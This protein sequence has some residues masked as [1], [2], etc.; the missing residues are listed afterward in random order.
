MEMFNPVLVHEYLTLSARRFP[1]KD[2]LVCGGERWTYRALDEASGRLAGALGR[3]GLNRQDRV[4]IFLENSAETVVSLYGTLKAGGIFVILNASLRPGKLGYILQDSGARFMIASGKKAGIVKAALSQLPYPPV[5]IWV[6]ETPDIIPGGFPA[7]SDSWKAVLEASIPEK[8]PGH[9][10][11]ECDL[12]TLIYTSGST[13]E[14]KG[15]M[16]THH[17]VVSAARSIIQY[18]ENTPEDILIDVLPLSFD[19]GLYQVIMAFMFGGTV[20]LEKS[21]LYPVTI[22]KAIERERVTG[23]PVVPTL[24]AMLLKMGNLSLYDLGSMRYMTNTAAALPVEHIRRLRALFPRVKLYSMYGLTECKRV[25]YLP[26]EELDRRPASVGKAIPNCEVFIVD[27]EG[28]RAAPG[29]AGELVIRGPNVMQ[30]YWNAP[31]LTARTFRP[32]R[33][34]DDRLLYSGDLFKMDADGFLYFLGRKDDMIKTKGER[35]SPREIENALCGMEGIAEAAVIGVPDEI[36]GEAVE[37]F[38]ALKPGIQV[39]EKSVLKQCAEQLESFLVPRRVKILSELPKSPNGK[40]DK[41][42]LREEH[43]ARTHSRSGLRP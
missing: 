38:V 28:R 41:K 16:S 4:A 11:P 35:V 7:G 5:V 13:G 1:G 37:A 10:C 39:R 32:G 19:Y 40:V 18:L 25:S 9:P 23:F 17:N 20:V 43:H 2:A 29:Q 31:E 3:M 34:P 27:E 30:G 42:A 33:Y 8:S 22:L 26:P 24:A 14:P 21:L 6:G 12:A 15:V 36:F